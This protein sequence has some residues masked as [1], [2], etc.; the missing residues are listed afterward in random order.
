M[1]PTHYNGNYHEVLGGMMNEFIEY[2]KIHLISLRQDF[3][4]E[5]DPHVRVQLKGSIETATHLLAIAEE[6]HWN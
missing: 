3:E 2:I 4:S 6:Y 5:T 1:P